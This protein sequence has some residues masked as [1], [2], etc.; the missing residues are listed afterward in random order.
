M[1]INLGENYLLLRDLSS[2]S[3]ASR[4][5]HRTLHQLDGISFSVVP[6]E[7]V[8]VTKCCAIEVEGLRKVHSEDLLRLYFEH[9][10]FGDATVEDVVFDRLRGKAVVTFK[11][12]QGM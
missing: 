8:E 3:V 1:E 5:F 11:H 6:L 12:S 10:K 9:Q 2:L 7:R 4:V